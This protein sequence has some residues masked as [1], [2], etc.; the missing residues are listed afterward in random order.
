MYFPLQVGE[1]FLL[2]ARPRIPPCLTHKDESRSPPLADDRP[3]A[4]RENAKTIQHF[5]VPYIFTLLNDSWLHI[6]GHAKLYY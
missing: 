5:S 2:S 4:K 3:A 6:L 1:T